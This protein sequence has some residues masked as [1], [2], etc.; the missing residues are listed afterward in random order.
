MVP[1]V[2]AVEPLSP[3]L[4]F[5]S[6]EV[7]LSAITIVA[8]L[9]TLKRTAQTLGRDAKTLLGHPATKIA[10]TSGNLILGMLFGLVPGFLPGE[11]IERVLVGI[12]VG[13]MSQTIYT[14]AKPMIPGMLGA[15]E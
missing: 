4:L 11:G 9:T 15:K 5:A 14:A 6:W 2:A 7:W 3:Q 1:E 10:L 13:F 12:V 8:V